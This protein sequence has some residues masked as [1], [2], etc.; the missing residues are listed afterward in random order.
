MNDALLA[1]VKAAVESYEGPKVN[2]AD[3]VEKIQEA[4]REAAKH[5]TEYIT[6]LEM[7]IK[8]K[9]AMLEVVKSAKPPEEM[10]VCHSI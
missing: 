9:E 8:E 2:I 5:S 1:S 6:Q 7:E 10:T 4:R 3:K